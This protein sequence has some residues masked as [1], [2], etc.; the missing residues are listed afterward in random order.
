VPDR[1]APA[2]QDVA[3]TLGSFRVLS[4]LSSVVTVHPDD[5]EQHVSPAS[6]TATVRYSIDNSKIQPPAIDTHFMIDLVLR[7]VTGANPDVLIPINLLYR[8]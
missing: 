6:P 3:P 1:R 4:T 8:V 7:D 5:V 2:L